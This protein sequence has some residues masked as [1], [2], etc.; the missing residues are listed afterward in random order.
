M[1]EE[2]KTTGGRRFAAGIRLLA[3]DLRDSSFPGKRGPANGLTN[4]LPCLRVEYVESLRANTNCNSLS[5]QNPRLNRCHGD[6]AP[7]SGQRDIHDLFVS[8]R[9]DYTDFAF[10]DSIAWRGVAD[11][12][13]V[14]R[15]HAE[16]N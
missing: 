15:P 1:N 6:S 9:L 4:A 11:N 7:T 3:Q 5:R 14:L 10:D 2:K 12:L 8:H 13:Q 16:E